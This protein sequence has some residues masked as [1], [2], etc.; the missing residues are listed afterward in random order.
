MFI[1]ASRCRGP[2]SQACATR[3]TNFVERVASDQIK[4]IEQLVIIIVARKK[5]NAQENGNASRIVKRSQT[6]R[7]WMGFASFFVGV[8]LT[9]VQ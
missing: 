7:P 3:H 4:E 1:V 6:H 2:K 5:G 9:A 8:I